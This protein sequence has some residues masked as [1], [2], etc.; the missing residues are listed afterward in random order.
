MAQDM[1]DGTTASKTSRTTSSDKNHAPAGPPR[2]T[3]RPKVQT[4]QGDGHGKELLRNL[5][6]GQSA[7]SILA[8]E[9]ACHQGA[10]AVDGEKAGE[11]PQRRGHSAVSNPAFRD[12]RS[13]KV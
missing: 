13:K 10:Q 11:Q 7:Y 2:I 3:A 1:N 6:N 9:E 8:G 5:H 12:F 4:D